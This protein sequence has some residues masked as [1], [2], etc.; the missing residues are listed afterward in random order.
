VRRPT[1]AGV[2]AL[3]EVANTNARETLD[4]IRDL[5]ADTDLG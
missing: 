3:R 1:A 2:R 4:Q 5:I